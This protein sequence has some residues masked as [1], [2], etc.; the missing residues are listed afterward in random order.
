MHV[1]MHMCTGPDGVGDYSVQVS[2]DG[3]RYVGHGI[4]SPEATNDTEHILRGA[5]VRETHMH[6]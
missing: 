5:P 4:R 3:N 6:V 2:R 1:C